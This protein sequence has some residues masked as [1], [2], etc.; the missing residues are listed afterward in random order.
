[1]AFKAE[2]AVEP[3]NWDFRPYVDAHGTTPEPSD[4]QVEAMNKALRDATVAVTGEDFDP[5]DRKVMAR[6]F[7][8]LT[9]VQLKA[10]ATANLDAIILVTGDCPSRKQIDG[11]PFRFKQLYMKSL[12]RD[13]NDP[14]LP[15]TATTS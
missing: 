1:M 10:M 4:G 7:G 8:K 12:V 14:E 2:D 5:D 3:L 15:A 6:I 9:D 11:L 13:I